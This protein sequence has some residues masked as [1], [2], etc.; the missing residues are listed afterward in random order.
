MIYKLRPYQEDC[1]KSIS[2]YINSD[3]H[4]PVLI[5]GPVGCGKSILI[6][7]AARLMGD[8]TLILQPSKELLQQNHDKITSYG[9]PATIY[10]A[11]CGKKELSN[12][13]YATLGSIKKVVD[14]LKEMGIRNVLIDEAHAGYSP[15]DGSEF[16]AFM[17]ELKPRKV[18]GFTATPCRLK[19]CR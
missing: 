8:K 7:E 9:I 13:I 10:S 4:D 18:I 6:A 14:K 5:V 2:D 17:N 19:T 3:R 1:V 15:E 12:M 11:S 16:M